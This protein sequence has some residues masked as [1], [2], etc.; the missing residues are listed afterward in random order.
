MTKYI[1]TSAFCFIAFCNIFAQPKWKMLHTE[2]IV[3][4]PVFK[5][6]HA[7]TIVEVAPGKLMASFFGGTGEGEKDVTIWLANCENGKWTAPAIIADGIINDSLR[8]PCWNPVLFKNKEGKLFLFYK[9]GPRP[10][11][12]WGM[13]KTSIDNG[14]TW[15]VPEKLPAGILGP[16]KNKPVQLE[17]GTMLSPSSKE[18]N[19]VWKVY[20]EKSADQGDSW[21][22]IPVDTS[23]IFKVIQPTILLYP[24]H[25]LQMLCRSNQDKIVQSWSNDNGKTWSKLSLTQLPNPNSGIDAVTL[26]NGWQMLVYNPTTKGKEW[27]NGRQKLNVAISKDGRTWKDVIVLENGTKEEFSYPAIIETSDGRVH[28][29]YTYDRKNIKHVVLARD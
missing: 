7:S 29:T 6:C 11:N 5:E 13:V 17:D 9:E 20:V 22:L 24:H 28:I 19:N 18:E 16:I 27:S 4:N 26:K 23:N 25:R 10:F 15:S 14:A 12:W 8:Y 1:L 3:Q 21:Q 2:M